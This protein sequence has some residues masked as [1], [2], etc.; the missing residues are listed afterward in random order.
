MDQLDAAARSIDAALDVN[1]HLTNSVTE[2]YWCVFID[3]PTREQS[4]R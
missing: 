4:I 1:I 3:T 2:A